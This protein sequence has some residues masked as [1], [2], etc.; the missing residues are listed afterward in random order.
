MLLL[1][2]AWL[3]MKTKLRLVER[4][5]KQSAMFNKQLKA[6]AI[7]GT[8]R[9]CTD[10]TQRLKLQNSSARRQIEPVTNNLPEFLTQCTNQWAKKGHI[11]PDINLPEF[12]T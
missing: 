1:T 6:K 8:K 9:V 3:T 4:K 12:P 11:I 7:Q 2:N 5:A 10:L